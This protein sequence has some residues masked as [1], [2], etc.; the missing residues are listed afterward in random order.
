MKVDTFIHN[1][2]MN[3][4]GNSNGIKP[5]KNKLRLN[6]ET[7]RILNSSDLKRVAGGQKDSAID[8]SPCNP[9]SING[10]ACISLFSCY[11]DIGC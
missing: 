3:S 6:K 1:E 8:T 5:L 10:H 2:K 4:E 7:V 9:T 11:P